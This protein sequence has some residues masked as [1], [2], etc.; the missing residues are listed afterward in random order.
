MTKKKPTKNEMEIVLSN[1]IRELEFIGRKLYALDN[2]F[3]LYLSWKKDK[4]KFDKFV[5]SRV[6]DAKDKFLSEKLDNSKKEP[7]DNK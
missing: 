3:G 4:D 5:K 7:G 6:D 2:V 1:V